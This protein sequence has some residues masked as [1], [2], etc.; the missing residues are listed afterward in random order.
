[1][2]LLDDIQKKAE[3]KRQQQHGEATFASQLEQTYS[4]H[5][6]PRLKRVYAFFNSL[7]AELNYLDEPVTCAYKIPG[8]GT[9]KNFQHS[10][11][12]IAANSSDRLTDIRI[13]FLCQRDTPIAFLVETEARAEQ[14]RD[15][16]HRLQVGF[17]HRP[18]YAKGLE[19]AATFFTLTGQIPVQ[20][21]LH[22]EPNS[23]NIVLETIN[24]PELGIFKKTLKPHEINDEFMDSLGRFMMRQHSNIDM[25][26]D[27]PHQAAGESAEEQAEKIRKQL[28]AKSH[29]PA[30]A[31][32]NKAPKPG[33]FKRLFSNKH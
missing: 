25:H 21:R 11:Y 8:A 24:L 26:A 10:H 27:S 16:L 19:N 20:I 32:E 12:R 17:E 13:N 31:Q 22:V 9:V 28:R 15:E 18:D 5:I 3:H 7:I 33:F 23:T 30:F 6:N 1:M 14:I 2:S 4:Q 29:D